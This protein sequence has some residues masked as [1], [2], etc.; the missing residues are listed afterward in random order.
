MQHKK[1]D[2]EQRCIVTFARSWGALSATRC[3]GKYGIDVI[4]GDSSAVAASNFSFYSNDFFT[5]PQ[6]EDNPE[7]YLD[8]IEQTCL[9]YK[10]PNR[11]LVLMPLHTDSYLIAKHRERFEGLVK[12]VLPN[13]TE[14]D[15][16]N[17]KASLARHCLKNGINTPPTLTADSVEEFKDKLSQFEYP[18]FL[19]P[20]ESLGSVGVIKVNSPKEANAQFDELLKKYKLDDKHLPIIQK[21]VGGDDFCATF[22]FDH[23]ELKASM[24][25][26]NIVDYPKDKGMGAIR[27]TVDAAEMEEMGSSLLRDLKWHGVA[28]IDFR[29]DGSS[30][31]W[32]IE[33]NPRFWGG[34][35]QSIASG[36]DYPYLL[37][38]LAIDGHVDSVEKT[39][40]DAKTF[41]PCLTL[42][43]ELEE[44]INAKNTGEELRNAF[45]EFKSEIK[46]GHLSVITKLLG[47][48][49]HA[50][51]PSKRI[52]AV[53][54]II[55]KDKSAVNEL[56][57]WRDPLPL[58]GLLYPLA[59]F[60]KHG[61]I[62][63]ELLVK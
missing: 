23:G 56:L 38:K 29:W 18:G 28:E 57:D 52:H 7:G 59:I 21:A 63:P 49:A 54:E 51:N 32:L 41:N 50:I 53:K 47:N 12:M 6:P 30:T 3:L 25:Y 36:I 9:N 15:L 55:N 10:A 58:L 44:F 24:T 60:V 40:C 31:P 48:V 39:N 45:K 27:E 62:T 1:E 8:A 19:K 14:I 22:L 34:L 2:R 61:K 35:G 11:D 42:L 33:I 20:P 5:Y 4:T 13:S 46:H 16:V 26:H 43:L 17:N 37:Y